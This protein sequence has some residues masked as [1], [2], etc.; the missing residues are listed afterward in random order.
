MYYDTQIKLA[1]GSISELQ[2]IFSRSPLDFQLCYPNHFLSRKVKILMSSWHRTCWI[3]FFHDFSLILNIYVKND[4]VL[5]IYTHYLDILNDLISFLP[6]KNWICTVA[7]QSSPPYSSGGW[8]CT[9]VVKSGWFDSFYK[10]RF[11]QEE[12]RLIFW[13]PCLQNSR[14]R[15]RGLIPW[16]LSLVSNVDSVA[17]VGATFFIRFNAIINWKMSKIS[18]SRNVKKGYLFSLD[19]KSFAE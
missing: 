19:N 15:Q 7:V 2:R 16:L 4:K 10:K 11:L 17:S 14:S 18:N 3:F 9:K 6:G 8:K 5:Q 12:G 13:L 1:P